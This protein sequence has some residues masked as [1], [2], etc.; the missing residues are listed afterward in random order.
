MASQS[1]QGRR[2]YRT[3][4]K[5]DINDIV[6]VT[7]TVKLSEMLHDFHDFLQMAGRQI[8][9]STCYTAV[10]VGLSPPSVC[11]PLSRCVVDAV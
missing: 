11:R 9:V 8:A 1:L 5:S 7:S 6:I 2:N 10:F 3:K 4:A